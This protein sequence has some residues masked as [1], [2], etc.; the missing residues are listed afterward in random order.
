MSQDFGYLKQCS[1]TSFSPNLP[2]Y[3]KEAKCDL[4]DCAKR[5]LNAVKCFVWVAFCIGEYD[6]P[7]LSH[8][9]T[10]TSEGEGEI[11]LQ[12]PTSFSMV[13]MTFF[14]SRIS[15]WM[16]LKKV[17]MRKKFNFFWCV[18]WHQWWMQQL[19]ENLQTMEK[20]R[21]QI[22]YIVSWRYVF[23]N[24]KGARDLIDKSS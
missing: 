3:G 1:V 12:L 8:Y 9:M 23:W 14:D 5:A 18:F 24:M 2:L 11:E 4:Q 21:F 10:W 17:R 19:F 16:L 15:T 7:L 22:L 6:R 20:F 13:Y